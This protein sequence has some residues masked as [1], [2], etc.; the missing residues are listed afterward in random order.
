MAED[1]FRGRAQNDNNNSISNSQ[2]TGLTVQFGWN[3]VAG[4]GAGAVAVAVTYPTAYSSILY[5][6]ATP[7]AATAADSTPATSITD[8]EVAVGGGAMCAIDD[9]TTSGCQVTYA[10]PSGT[11]TSTRFYAF[12]WMAI[13]TV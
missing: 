12:S 13:G 11:L 10:I 1:F 5:V 4:N 6:G 9:I 2:A 7:L 3:Q 8:I